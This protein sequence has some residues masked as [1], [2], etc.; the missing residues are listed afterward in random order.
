MR[1]AHLVGESIE[2]MRRLAIVIPAYKAAFL[3]ETL[4]SIAAQTCKDFT[5]YIG[6]DA[7]P[8]D[9]WSI[10]E[11]WREFIDLRYHRF[12]QNLGNQ[13]LVAQWERC[14]ALSVEP[15]IW[16]FGDDDIMDPGCVEMFYRELNI[17][18]SL[19][20]IF[21]FN[22]DVIDS[23]GALILEPTGFP[24]VLSANDFAMRRFCSVL[25]S[26][27][28]EYLFARNALERVGGIQSFPRAWCSDDATWI[29]L[30][31]EP[32]IRTI[33]GPKVKWRFSGQN[34]SAMH[35][36]DRYEKFEAAIQYI[37]WIS[38]Y[39]RLRPRYEVEV[40]IELNLGRKWL[41]NQTELLQVFFCSKGIWKSA[42]RLHEVYGKSL[43]GELI[44][45]FLCDLRAL[46]KRR[47][48]FWDRQFLSR[49]TRKGIY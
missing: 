3:D 21:H 11:P 17:S 47:I 15:W 32:G 10:C 49:W 30:A 27:A 44:K 20:D 13:N 29:K 22:V 35:D 33:F 40:P 16:L 42:F 25:P 12:S 45:L 18:G 37:E 9:V 46:R 2:P 24:A 28:P 36:Q 6:D 14:I 23:V 31:G 26:Y 41:Y 38:Q 5:V 34:I 48:V 39:F 4:R 8:H 19:H 7:S 43:L 1:P